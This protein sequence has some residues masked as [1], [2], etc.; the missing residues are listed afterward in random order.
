LNKQPLPRSNQA[1]RSASVAVLATLVSLLFA[2]GA[3]ASTVPASASAIPASASQLAKARAQYGAMPIAFEENRGQTDAAVR[4]LSRG[5]GYGLFLTS[6]E[7]VLSLR[8]ANTNAAFRGGIGQPGVAHADA[9]VETATIRLSFDGA[10]RAPALRGVD[11][12]AATTNY[13]RGAQVLRDV[14]N[15]SKV[16]YED[17]YPGVDLVYYGSQQG[18]L[19]YDFVV[20]P[21]SDPSPIALD[22]AGVRSLRV[23]ADGDL[24]LGTAVG[25]VV[26]HAPV[27]YQ[28][29]AGERRMV[30]ASYTRLGARKIGFRLGEYDRSREL[31]IDPVLVY[32]TYHGGS[33]GDRGNDIAIDGSSN[34]YVIGTANSTNFPSLNGFDNTKTDSSSDV[35]VSKFSPTGTLVYSTFIGG[36]GT[37]EG[38]GVA[39][40]SSGNAYVTGRTTSVDFPVANAYQSA[41]GGSQD[42]FLTKLNA[43]GN[44]LVFSTF[45]GGNS[46]PNGISFTGEFG[47]A[48]AVDSANSAYVT[49]YAVSTNFPVVNAFQSTGG[50]AKDDVFV[51]KFAANG[52][53]LVYS[54]YLG[55]ADFDEG[56]NIAVDSAGSA[57]ITGITGSTNFPL[58]NARQGL[59][60]SN[61]DAFL[62]KFSPAGNTLAYSTYIGGFAQDVGYGIAVDGSGNAYVAGVTSSGNFPVSG[63]I[64]SFNNGGTAVATDAFV[65]KFNAAGNTVAY[66]TW[67]GGSGNESGIGLAVDPSGNAYVVGQT[68]STN[69]PTASPIQAS[70]NGLAD[71]FLTKLTASGNA[72]VYS[73]YLGG[74]G[75]DVGNDIAV[76][77]AGDAFI[78]GQTA[79]SNFP[80]ASPRQANNGGSSDA[81]VTRISTSNDVSISISDVAITEGNSGTVNAVFTVSLGKAAAGTVTFTA[82]TANGTATAG[83]DYTATT[84]AGQ[85]IAAGQ[86]SKTISVPVIGDTVGEANETFFVNLSAVS[87]AVV[88]D[89]QGVGTINNDDAIVPPTLSINDMSVAEGNSGT[90]TMTFTV[91]VSP[92]S[93]NTVG[94]DIATAN[95]SATAGSDYVASALSGQTIAAG[96]ST[97][98]FSV[99]INGDT[100]VEGNETF[101]VNLSNPTGGAVVG[102]GQ[103]QGTINNDDSA[104]VPVLSVADVSVTEGN[105]GTSTM[106]FT[107]SLSQATQVDVGFSVFTSNNTAAAGS[108][109]VALNL[110]G[111]SIPAGQTSKSFAVTINGD[112]TLENNESFFF[113]VG[114]VSNATV[115]DGQAVGTINNDDTAVLPVLSINDVTVNEG[116]SG[117]SIATFTVS[118][119]TVPSSTVGFSVATANGSATAGSDY[120]ALSLAGQSIAAGQTFKTFS[121]TINGDTAVEGNETFFLNVSSVSG[122]TVGDGQGQG[123]IN[124]D[125]N[126]QALV[127]DISVTDASSAEGT[128]GNKN[129]VFTVQ[130]SQTTTVPVN[131]TIHT[132]GATAFENNDFTAKSVSDSIPAGQTSYQFAVALETDSEVEP[133]ENFTVNLMNVSGA[134]VLDAQGL[135]TIVNDDSAEVSIAPVS[136]TEGNSGIV[137]ATFQISLSMP[138]P[139]PVSFDIATGGGT[140]SAGSDYVARSINGMVLDAGRTKL[141]FDVRVNG[142]NSAEGNETFNVTLS[143]ITGASPNSTQ[144]TGTILNDDSAGQTIGDVQGKGQLSPLEGQQATVEGVVTGLAEDGFY[145]QSADGAG[146]GDAATSDGVFVASATRVQLGDL[147]EVG[148]TVREPAE[149]ADQLTQTRIVADAVKVLANDQALPA[150]TAVDATRLAGETV[151]ALERYEGMRVS[152]PQLQVVAPVGGRVDESTG[153]V[154]SNGRFYAVA[155]GL[156]R[157]F[158]E[159]GLSVFDRASRAGVSPAQFDANPERLMIE[160]LG[161]RGARALSADT[162]DTVTGLAGILGY[163]AGAYRLLP[164]PNGNARIVSGAAPKAVSAT[165]AGQASVG[166]FDLRRLL[167]DRRDGSEQVLASEAYAIR[168]AKTANAICAYARTPDVL[169]VAGIEGKA[170]LADLAAAVNANVGNELFPGACSGNAGYRGYLLAGTDSKQRN[171]GFLVSE[172]VKVGSVAQIGAAATFRNRDGSAERLNERPSLVLEGSIDGV[173]LTVVANHLAALEGDLAAPGAK[174]WATQGDYLRAKRAAQAA[175]LASWIQTRQASRPAEKLVVL[176]DFAASEFND[177][178][179]DL[180]G[181]VTGRPT[182]RGR[183]LAYL[184]SPVTQPLTNLT[185][186]LPRAERYTVTRDGNAQAVDHI[187]VNSALL[188]A[189]AKAE[190]ARINADFGEEYLDDAGVPMRVSDHDPV[191]LRFD[192]H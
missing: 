9:D 171:I 87:G 47:Y 60:G 130:L 72:M 116:N 94:F 177:G 156:A 23:N 124:N 172:R 58:V 117:T 41:L 183:V 14:A 40:D 169:G 142:D 153:T 134:S 122:A 82:A 106:T 81:F 163:G 155:K 33:L 67:L 154:R 42:A 54:T 63:Q 45:L 159:P 56:Y 18:Q 167:D 53:S 73:T 101:F 11:P 20:A 79:S 44:G 143:N 8:G 22:F 100:A 139:T 7:A 95:G 46:N 161:L 125:D 147:L 32:S 165:A 21:G 34:A 151:T 1:T 68:T 137:T 107:V 35:F 120:V 114:S 99:T 112:T 2:S 123:T 157:P 78:T 190:V 135:G 158:V 191:V 108:D 150:A 10:N 118:L 166:S 37:D 31:V 76:N 48:V 105:S 145:L 187:L 111:Q 80:T 185:T 97:K 178:H 136:V 36:I 174:G 98:T 16:R 168:L 12:Q 61:Q 62:A 28:D 148:G 162:G 6:S 192:L 132:S 43:N 93:P 90:S 96:Q 88:A 74:G 140:A 13:F 186:A 133:N 127:P 181:M 146:D 180:L 129:L 70:N 27:V 15:F 173:A 103:G 52:A 30:A 50:G 51:T 188:S 55:G 170:A 138:M 86:T 149:G 182:A 3:N 113:N 19:E 128:N 59:Y 65:A 160:S 115:G 69:F 85:T 126:P 5:P 77:S 109:Y 119:N 131:F 92:T 176:G 179:A 91:S 17:L 104:T 39:V 24:V 175:Y 75:E 110:T 184:G 141:N 121:V 49:G 57:Y 25:D 26:Q 164:E 102:D 144:A 84:L 89:G 83:S 38:A 71:V 189:N 4:F 64:Q 66:V 29:V 152:L